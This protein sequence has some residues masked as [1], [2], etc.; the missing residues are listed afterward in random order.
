M[1]R[2]NQKYLNSLQVI[3]DMLMIVVAFLA[4]YYV[5]FFIMKD[6]IITLEFI[7]NFLPILLMLPVYFILYSVF[8]LYHSRR[9]KPFAQEIYSILVAN[10]LGFLILTLG[11]FFFDLSDFS[12]YNLGLFLIFNIGGTLFERGC[13]RYLLR[14]YRK[15]GFNLKHCL[16]VGTSPTTAQLL[17]KIKA[18]PYWG[19]NI[20]GI[21]RSDGRKSSVFG[22]YPILGNVEDLP[23][24]LTK[25][26]A[27]IVMIATDE[28]SAEQLGTLLKVCETSGVKTHIIPYYHKYVPAKPYIDDLD[29]LPI[30]DTRH[31]PLDN[32]FCSF[33][34]RA[35]DIAF[36]LVAIFL[37]SPL[38]IFCAVMIKCSSPGPILFKQERVGA[39]RKSFWMYKFRSMRVQT[40]EEEKDKWTTKDDPRKT[41][42]G[43]FMRRTSID[44]LPQFFNVLKGEMS[45][46]GPRPERPYF[47]EKFKQE[48]PRYMIKH[49]V[50]PGIT[51]WA[52]VNGYR[53]DTSIEDRIAHDL[54]YI[55]NWTLS[56]D[57]KIILM[58]LWSGFINKNAY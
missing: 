36:S 6:G 12:R 14:H 48:V 22:G 13:I 1:I 46:V 7:R 15:R 19:Y 44:E 8:D 57:F 28:N 29:G 31:V 47:V 43:S 40:D 49:Q 3:L 32:P 27:D 38:L 33:L 56:F 24:I 11:L 10:L 42:W 34:K 55:E 18:H 37:I 16:V 54:Y 25:Y 21:I 50:R 35:F 26:Y 9:I 53:G 39:N 4:A 17:D 52:Q 30:I 20:L 23:H 41:W 51:G 58:T 5:R 45:V 2:Q